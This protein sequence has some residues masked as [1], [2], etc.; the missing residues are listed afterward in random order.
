MGRE[1]VEPARHYKLTH[2]R[3][4]RVAAIP[5]SWLSFPLLFVVP[6]SRGQKLERDKALK[7]LMS[8]C[9]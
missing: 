1:G 3:Q 2:L 5:H 9:F 7:G 8:K 6:V 4:G